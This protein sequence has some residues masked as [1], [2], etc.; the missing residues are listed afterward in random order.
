MR[1]TFENWYLSS[2]SRIFASFLAY[3][4]FIL[5]DLSFFF[6]YCLSFDSFAPRTISM[7]LFCVYVF[8]FGA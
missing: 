6:E 5:R 4:S 1:D 7:Q 2:F 8:I 3:L